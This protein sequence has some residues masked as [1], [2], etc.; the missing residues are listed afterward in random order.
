MAR[1]TYRV[2]PSDGRFF[3]E[4][5]EMEAEAEGK[6]RDSAVAALKAAICERM[7]A[8]DA[9]APPAKAVPATVELI[10]ASPVH[11]S[12]RGADQTGDA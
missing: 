4:C 10:E 11:P 12:T 2:T 5:L 6:T 3:A 8:S 9:V 1:Y 7:S